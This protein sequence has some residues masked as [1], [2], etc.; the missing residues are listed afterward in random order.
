M[1]SF[2]KRGRNRR[3]IFESL[4]KPSIHSELTRKIYGKTSN[5]YFNMVSRG[6]SEFKQ[7]KLIVVVNPKSKT[8][9]IYK[10]TKFGKLVEQE[11][12]YLES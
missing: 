3:N 9:R 4:N 12:K 8:G 7:N 10:K 11:L 1:V 2:I 6:L 5:T